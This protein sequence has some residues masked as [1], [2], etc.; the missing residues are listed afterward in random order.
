MKKS[1]FIADTGKTIK[2]TNKHPVTMEMTERLD[3]MLNEYGIMHFFSLPID[4]TDGIA[5]NDEDFLTVFYSSEDRLAFNLVYA[6]WCKTVRN[7]E[8]E[9]L[10]S[11]LTKLGKEC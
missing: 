1:L 6:L 8:D 3:G 7:I 11:A 10:Y 4:S 5:N 9:L 2:D